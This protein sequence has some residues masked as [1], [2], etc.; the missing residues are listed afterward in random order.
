MSGR[1]ARGEANADAKAAIDVVFV[2]SAHTLLLDLAGPAEALRL[3][4]QHLRRH[5]A[6]EP[7]RL[8]Y[9]GP[10]ASCASSVGLTFAGLEPLPEMLERPTWIVLLGQPSDL[11]AGATRNGL[12]ACTDWLARTVA[13]WL[14]D[15]AHRLVTICAGTMLAARAGLLGTRRCTTH[16]ELLPQLKAAAPQAQ[17][18]DNR[19]FV[20]DGTLASSAGITAGIDLTL[21]LIAET[22]GDAVAASIARNMVVYLRRTPNDPELSPL[23]AH[24]HHL[25]PVV[26]KVQDAVCADPTRD[27]TMAALADA[28]HVTERHLLRLFTTHAAVSPLHYLQAI[29]LERARQALSRGTSVGRAATDAGFS[30]DLQLRRAWRKQFA[31]SPGQAR[32]DQA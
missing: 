11:P 31:G 14:A 17:V 27:W 24:R 22:C 4:N 3:A 30:S 32:M 8:R 10:E 21:H 20:V 18:I 19:V 26:H 23:L 25:H 13:P 29:R 28:G 6:R 2:V 1:R 5:G 15:P 7:F 16:H 9:A 12:A